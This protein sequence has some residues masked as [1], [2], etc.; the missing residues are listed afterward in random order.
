MKPQG[1]EGDY[2]SGELELLL[3]QAFQT[4]YAPQEMDPKAAGA[5]GAHGQHS[6]G[7]PGWDN[8]LGGLGREGVGSMILVILPIRIFHDLPTAL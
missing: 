3:F 5:P 6:Q 8:M 2:G 1:A 4:L 7:C